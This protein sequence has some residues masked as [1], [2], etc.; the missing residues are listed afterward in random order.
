MRLRHARK[1]RNLTQQRLASL[2]GIKQGSISD[3]ERGE[4]KAFRGNTLL[5]LAK[6]LN[7]SPEWLSHGRG[8]MERR[9][10]PLSDEA[11]A[12]AQA[13]QRL[14]PE[15]QKSTKEMILS[16]AE[17][18]DKYGPTVSDDRVEEAYGRPGSKARR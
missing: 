8:S 3:L 6:A 15:L 5:S 1:A 17:Q 13:W 10:V 4:S 7:V 11:M 12:V 14:V 2:S 18:A 16:M 9:D